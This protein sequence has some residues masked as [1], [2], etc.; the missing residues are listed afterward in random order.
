MVV[1]LM[2]KPPRG[3]SNM[4]RD[5]V[6]AAMAAETWY[7]AGEAVEAGLATDVIEHAEVSAQ[8]D[9]TVYRNTPGA[10]LNA[11]AGDPTERDI[12]RALRD[13]GLSRKQ[14]RE[15]I[16]R[17]R[18]DPPQWDAAEDAAGLVDALTSLGETMRT[19][20]A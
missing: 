5:E 8:F 20:A 16:A 15:M 2:K 6:I 19:P 3:R 1:L 14:A 11:S 12:E 7:D 18:A 4:E 10:L 9:Y 17:N 13:A